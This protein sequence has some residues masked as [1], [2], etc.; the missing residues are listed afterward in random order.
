ML[1]CMYNILIGRHRSAGGGDANACMGRRGNNTCPL[2]CVA[3]LLCVCHV[4]GILGANVAS[5]YLHQ[6]PVATSHTTG[7]Y[8]I[9]HSSATSI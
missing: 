8:S 2:R 4:Q 6:L 9:V 3:Y 7:R 1:V 5:G